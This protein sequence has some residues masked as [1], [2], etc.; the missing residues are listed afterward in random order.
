MVDE[1]NPRAVLERD[2]AKLKTAFNSMEIMYTA[3]Q[4]ALR[5]MNRINKRVNRNNSVEGSIP[6]DLKMIQRDVVSIKAELADM[7]SDFTDELN[8]I[9]EEDNMKIEVNYE[10]STTTLHKIGDK[11]FTDEQIA[12]LQEVE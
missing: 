11:L 5:E 12:E 3:T 1:N 8:K 2:I 4:I 9:K 6:M 7:V 10:P